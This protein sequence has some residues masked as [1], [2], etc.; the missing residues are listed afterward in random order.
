MIMI[1]NAL[2]NL[3]ML[4][5]LLKAITGTFVR[6]SI[7]GKVYNYRS[8]CNIKNIEPEVEFGDVKNILGYIFRI[9]FKKTYFISTDKLEILEAVENKYS[10]KY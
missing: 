1:V 8:Y 7:I 4:F 6:A 2:L 5:F 9:S 10:R 3:I